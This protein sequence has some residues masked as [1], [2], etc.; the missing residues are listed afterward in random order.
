M[1]KRLIKNM[2]SMSNIGII[3]Q[4]M[5]NRDNT[6]ASKRQVGTNINVIIKEMCYEK[7]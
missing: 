7:I 1:M 5:K 4:T 6:S 3:K 2:N